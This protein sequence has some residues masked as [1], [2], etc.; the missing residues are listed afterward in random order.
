MTLCSMEIVNWLFIWTVCW[1]FVWYLVWLV[2]ERLE[3]CWIC[4]SIYTSPTHILDKVVLSE[5]ILEDVY[6]FTLQAQLMQQK[7]P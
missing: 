1:F 7:S 2:S 6:T 5:L 3:K 4:N